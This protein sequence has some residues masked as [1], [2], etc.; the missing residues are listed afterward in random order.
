MAGIL[1]EDGVQYAA[2]YRLPFACD[3]FHDAYLWKFVP[4]VFL[5]SYLHPLEIAAQEYA[6]NSTLCMMMCA[7]WL[8]LLFVGTI[9]VINRSDLE[10]GMR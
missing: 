3:I 10:G 8:P 7:L 4:S 9:H 2:V 5:D 1:A 6:A